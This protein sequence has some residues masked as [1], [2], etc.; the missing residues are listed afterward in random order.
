MFKTIIN[1]YIFDLGISLMFDNIKNNFNISKSKYRIPF[2][3]E[4]NVGF[5]CSV[6]ITFDGENSYWYDDMICT[7]IGLIGC[8]FRDTD[9]IKMRPLYEQIMS[10]VV[11][12]DFGD[13]EG[14]EFINNVYTKVYTDSDGNIRDEETDEII[15]VDVNVIQNNGFINK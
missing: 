11:V 5:K 7:E 10:I 9:G 8:E 13:D 12:E 6:C 14:D 3:Q 4:L 15:D 1:H 2:A